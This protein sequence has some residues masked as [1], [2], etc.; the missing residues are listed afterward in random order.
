MPRRKFL[1]LLRVVAVIFV[2]FI[3]VLLTGTAKLYQIPTS[4][5]SPTI[6]AGDHIFSTRIFAPAKKVE[7]GDVVVFDATRAH[8]TLK[9]NYA[10]RVVALGGDRIEW[11]GSELRVNGEA[12]PERAG[13]KP[14]LARGPLRP[15]TPPPSYPLTVPAGTIFTMGDNYGNSLDSRYFGP[16]PIDAVMHSADYIATPASRAGKIE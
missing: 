10:Q 11:D 6:E 13:L 16:F 4:G 15:G 9:G 8:P 12:L 14:Q 3:L 7:R 1:F 5:M 2:V